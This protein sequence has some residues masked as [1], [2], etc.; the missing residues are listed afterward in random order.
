MRRMSRL[1]QPPWV[2]CSSYTIGSGRRTCSSHTRCTLL[3]SYRALCPPG[4]YCNGHAQHCL[5]VLQHTARKPHSQHGCIRYLQH[6]AHMQQ[7]HLLHIPRYCIR[8]TGIDL[9]RCPALLRRIHVGSGCRWHPRTFPPS[10][11]VLRQHQ[12]FGSRQVP[13]SGYCT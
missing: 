5:S 3:G 6:T 2:V 11:T 7:H 8:Y 13:W 10:C 9:R 4:S 1:D 12:S